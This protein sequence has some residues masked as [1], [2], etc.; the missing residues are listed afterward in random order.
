M[1]L[2]MIL[3]V[4]LR[5]LWGNKLRS[6]LAMLGIVIGV[7]AVIA[8][9]AIGAG[10]QKSVMERMTAMGTNL[11]MIRPGQRGSMGVVS[12]T[13][14]NL[15]VDD[16]L[17]ITQQIKGVARVAPALSGSGQLKYFGRNTRST[18]LGTTITYFYAR[19][20]ELQAGSYFTDLDDE[21]M[22]R[23]AVIGPVTAENLFG[24]QDPIGQTIKINGLNFRVIGLLKSKGDQGWF[25]PDDQALIPLR[26]AMKQ[27]YGLDFVR[28]INVQVE[29]GADISKVQQDVSQLLRR[30][31]RLWPGMPDD[32]FIRNQTEMLETANAMTRTFTILLG[33]IAC[34]SLLVGGIGIMN[35]ML[36]NVTEQTREIGIRRAIGA[37]RSDIVAQFLTESVVLCSVGGIAGI[38][39]GVG[40]PLAVQHFT[41]ITAVIRLWSVLLAFSISSGM[42]IVFG[43]YPAARAARMDP[44]QALRN[45]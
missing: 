14:Q 30:R 33:S 20:F 40:I 36:V 16:A 32:F 3:K 12:G 23:V 42:G 10:A 34:I 5:S 38:G 9:L 22:S 35:I 18:V 7:G 41:G 37:R 15:T 31:H 25:N 11:L 1:M 26:T 4:A 45:L 6:T 17:A 39:L 27:L 43:I 28:E 21:R 8:M 2:A 29:Q 44:I 19:N 13:A 24:A